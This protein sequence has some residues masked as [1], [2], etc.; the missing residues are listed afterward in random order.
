MTDWFYEQT[1]MGEAGEGSGVYSKAFLSEIERLQEGGTPFCVATVVE[2]RGSIPQIV[3]ARAVFTQDG[4]TQGTVGGGRVETKCRDIARE[5]LER[6]KGPATAFFHWNL[7]RDVGMT[8]S[9]EMTLFFEVW[10]P[11]LAWT[12]AIFGAG[13]VAQKLVRVLAELECR[14]LCIDT[15]PEWIARLPKSDK[16]VPLQVKD[17]VE[18]LASLPPGAAVLLM[19]MGHHSDR[20][21]L[22]ALEKADPP[23]AFLGVI[24]SD[25]KAKILKKELRER[26]VGPAFLKRIVCPV[27]DK[28]GNNTPGEIAIGIVAQLLRV[29]ADAGAKDG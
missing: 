15:R 9:G 20:P 22:E 27:G 21:V 29:R 1:V 3:G 8:C 16:I 5:L 13:H 14:V 12:V 23:L 4:L 10:R 2:G 11:E 25:A 17:Y 7:A 6:P 18:G 19:T 24:G 26:G 28:L